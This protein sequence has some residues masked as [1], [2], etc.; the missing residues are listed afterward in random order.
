MATHYDTLGVDDGADP[1]VVRRAYL[2]M[3]RRLHPDRWIDASPAERTDV[4]RRMQEV[5]EAWRVLGNPARR[6]AYDTGRRRVRPV[7]APVGAPFVSGDLFAVDDRPP[8][9]LVTWLVRALPWV[10]VLL[11]LGGIFVFSAYATSGGGGVSASCV[12]LDGGA[13]VSVPCSSEAAREVVVRVPD[14]ARCPAGTDPFQPSS[15]GQALCLDR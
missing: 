9:D 8:P 7:S 13:A 3:A 12:R 15:G 5:Y 10:L 2:E 1:E 14:V 11:A 6:L 4:E